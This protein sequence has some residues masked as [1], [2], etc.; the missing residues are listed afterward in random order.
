MNKRLCNILDNDSK[1]ALNDLEKPRNSEF[2]KPLNQ[3]KFEYVNEYSKSQQ[4]KDMEVSIVIAAIKYFIFKKPL[5]KHIDLCSK[6]RTR[7]V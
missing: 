6:A 4:Q 3:V 5:L 2:H 1:I 7:Y